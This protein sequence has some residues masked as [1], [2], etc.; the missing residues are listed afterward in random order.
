M[1]FAMLTL[2]P[3]TLMPRKQM[4]QE[5]RSCFLS[6]QKIARG[7]SIVEWDIVWVSGKSRFELLSKLASDPPHTCNASWG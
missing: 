4:S 5:N 1:Q 7:V 3:Q 2:L 6:A